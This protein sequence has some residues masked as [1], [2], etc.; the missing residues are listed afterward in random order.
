MA[1]FTA[2]TEPQALCAHIE[3]LQ[4]SENEGKHVCVPCLQVHVQEPICADN[5]SD[6]THIH[7]AVPKYFILDYLLKRLGSLNSILTVW[8]RITLSTFLEQLIFHI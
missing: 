6:N 2:S 3:A 8:C 7:N 5:G 4:K 1:L